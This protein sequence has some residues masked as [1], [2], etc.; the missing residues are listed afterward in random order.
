MKRSRPQLEVGSTE[1]ARSPSTVTN[2]RYFNSKKIPMQYDEDPESTTDRLH[3]MIK[4]QSH[5]FDECYDYI[6]APKQSRLR[7]WR[8]RICEWYY[9][10][11]DQTQHDRAVASLSINL[12]DRYIMV[13]FGAE[14]IG[15]REYYLVA[16]TC[17]MLGS[18]LSVTRLTRRCHISIDFLI[19]GSEKKFTVG[20]VE[21]VE[22]DILIQLEWRFHPP[23][24]SEFIHE[25]FQ[26]IPRWDRDMEWRQLAFEHAIYAAELSTIVGDP[27]KNSAIMA[28]V[29][30]L[31]ALQTKPIPPIYRNTFDCNASLVMNLSPDKVTSK[32][33]D[34]H[35]LICNAFRVCK[36]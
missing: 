21:T 27:I 4:Q 5:Y 10:V 23:L 2:V 35:C 20:E 25:L 7:E 28:Y 22:R 11:L 36:T 13:K 8:Q 30:V 12:L 6:M 32:V 17:L 15:R 33:D 19:Y 16:M 9:G 26:L 18:K 1:H 3:V 34:I 29:C 31:S 24:V 14:T